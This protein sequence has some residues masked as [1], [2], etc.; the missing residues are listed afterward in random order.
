MGTERDFLLPLAAW[1]RSGLW[2]ERRSRRARSLTHGLRHATQDPPAE[3]AAICPGREL[4]AERAGLAGPAAVAGRLEPAEGHLI[5]AAHL[6]GELPV[7]VL[8]RLAHGGA[9][10]GDRPVAWAAR[11]VRRE[12]GSCCWTG[13]PR[14][15]P[16][17]R[18][19]VLRDEERRFRVED[20][21]RLELGAPGRDLA[22]P[23]LA[24]W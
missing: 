17:R 3:R 7:L 13:A 12:D 18:L 16:G 22:R 4:E 10:D 21:L 23:G 11:A 24:D 1:A 14:A 2:L 20:L 6:G 8:A 19:L 5:G 15:L 9:C